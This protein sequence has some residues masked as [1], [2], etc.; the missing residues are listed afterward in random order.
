MVRRELD[1]AL[2]DYRRHLGQVKIPEGLRTIKNMVQ[3]LKTDDSG[4][5]RLQD[6][7]GGRI[8][9]LC[10]GI[11]KYRWLSCRRRTEAKLEQPRCYL[12]L[13]A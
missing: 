12:S 8:Q 1:L 6:K 7:L 3:K 5:S 4:V 10:G 13:Q 11:E 9:K 2:E